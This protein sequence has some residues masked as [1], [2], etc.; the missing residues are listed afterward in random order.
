[1]FMTG[2]Y[3]DQSLNREIKNSEN[4]GKIRSMVVSYNPFNCDG[5]FHTRMEFVHFV[6]I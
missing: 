5:L 6:L 3:F 2:E 1:M 4:V